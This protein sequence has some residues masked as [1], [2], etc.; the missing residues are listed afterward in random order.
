MFRT[1]PPSSWP[2][3]RETACP[4]RQNAAQLVGFSGFLLTSCPGSRPLLGRGQNRVLHL[5]PGTQFFLRG[6]VHGKLDA[7]P[8]GWEGFAGLLHEVEVKADRLSNQAARGLQGSGGGHAAWQVGY[9]D[10]VA[11][12]RAPQE[13]QI[14]QGGVLLRGRLVS[15]FHRRPPV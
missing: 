1:R 9:I 5:H 7:L 10:A 14:T 4:Q 8:W 11:S 2:R 13:H 12:S 15:P 6:F 3:S